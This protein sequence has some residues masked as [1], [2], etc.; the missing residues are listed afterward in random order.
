MKYVRITQPVEAFRFGVETSPE[1]FDRAVNEGLV[2]YS[3]NGTIYIDTLQ[4]EFTATEGDYIV[5]DSNGI[6]HPVKPL[7]FEANYVKYNRQWEEL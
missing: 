7:M 2:T 6:P 1:W 4:G 5:C 3:N